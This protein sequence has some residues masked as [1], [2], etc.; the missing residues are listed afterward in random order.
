MIGTVL[1]DRYEI[2][3]HLGDGGVASVWRAWD[4]TLDAEV[5]VKLLHPHLARE[6][7]AADRARRE[8]LASRRVPGAVTIHE[9]VSTAEQ[10]FLVQ[11]LCPGGDLR[12]RVDAG[13]LAEAEVIAIGVALGRTLQGAHDVGVMH[14]DV[15]PANVL[16]D[17]AGQPRLTD[18]GLARLADRAGATS[19]SM[20]AGS[21]GYTA[22][23]VYEGVLDDPRSDQYALAATL[24]E[25]ATG[26]LPWGDAAPAAVMR[27]QIEEVAPPAD[28]SPALAG[29]LA[30]A[31]A[32]RPE[33]R[34]E[35]MGAFAAALD[36]A[37]HGEAPG[38]AA[39]GHATGCAA[40]GEPLV[41]GLGVC[42]HCGRAHASVQRSAT[43]PY[44]VRVYARRRRRKFRL[45]GGARQ[46]G[47]DW[48]S[49]PEKQA[50]VATAT[51]LTGDR[52]LADDDL[53]NALARP[54]V[55]AA[56]GLD[57]AGADLV[58]ER[59]GSQGL[60][61]AVVGPDAHPPSAWVWPSRLVSM[62]PFLGGLAATAP[63]IVTLTHRGQP[64]SPLLF[65]PLIF[66]SAMGVL[67]ARV[68]Q[69]RVVLAAAGERAGEAAP[70]FPAAVGVAVR[71]LRDP[72][73]RD[74]VADVLRAAAA[75]RGAL[76]AAPVPARNDG[77]AA[78]AGAVEAALD[79][80]ARLDA[81]SLSAP[82]GGRRIAPEVARRLEEEASRREAASVRIRGELL[83][84]AAELRDTTT[85]VA[86]GQAAAAGDRARGA[87]ARLRAMAAAL[88]GAPPEAARAPAEGAEEDAD[89]RLRARAAER[90]RT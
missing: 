32:R 6:P 22:P 31:L 7:G 20:L 38:T 85:S 4:R 82:R 78:V 28:V 5:A 24:Y 26:A 42:P 11:E 49:F 1:A 17:A 62:L 89:R 41:P 80:G 72:A 54:V 50:L 57:R 79:L 16:V 59:L 56:D 75:L 74:L 43:G 2:R 67:L 25:L 51:E 3:G 39:I 45:D 18:F 30:R 10:T 68:Y 76:E 35:T 40:C 90:A 12:Q 63:A 87:T 81:L 70:A 8:V 13:P 14:R 77:E 71:A 23:E 48:L 9:L 33:A 60:R 86:A 58:A 83:R 21:V 27:R 46:R 47:L 36:A 53:D 37:G 34:F 88:E 19:T 55:V 52:A 66:A 61:A 29:V 44:A 73:V 64:L 84:L 69:P 65:L 15:K